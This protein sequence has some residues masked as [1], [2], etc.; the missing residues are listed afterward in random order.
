MRF[1]YLIRRE[2]DGFATRLKRA[3][4]E[5]SDIKGIADAVKSGKANDYVLRVGLLF[6]ELDGDLRVLVPA[7]F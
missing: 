4:E 6:K 1:F 3:Q 2:N 5:D 7:Y